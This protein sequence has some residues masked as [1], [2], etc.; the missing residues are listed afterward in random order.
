MF[1]KLLGVNTD[2]GPPAPKEGDLFK[3]IRLYGKTFELRYGFYEECDRHT[4]YAEPVAIYPDFI[5]QP[6]YTHEGLPFVT[7]MQAPCEHFDGRK[8]EDS[9]CGECIFY[10][11]CEELLGICDCPKNRRLVDADGI[12]QNE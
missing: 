9:G 1:A 3:T 12:V 4:P 10:R 2:Q 8:N 5:K 11:C 7:E 6:Q